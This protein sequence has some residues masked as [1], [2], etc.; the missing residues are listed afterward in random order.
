MTLSVAIVVRC[1]RAPAGFGS[2]SVALCRGADDPAGADSA[3]TLSV[4]GTTVCVTGAA[5][6]FGAG[7]ST[8]LS[9]T[10]TRDSRSARKKRLSIRARDH[11]RPLSADGIVECGQQPFC[12]PATL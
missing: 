6:F 10:T 8:W 1:S 12:F 5:V 4:E 2:E 7:K 9:A 11:S 3:F